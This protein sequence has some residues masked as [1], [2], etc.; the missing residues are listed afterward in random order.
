MIRALLALAL[1]FFA[2]VGGFF[3]RPSPYARV[4]G[5]ARARSRPLPE[6]LPA[7]VERFYR[8]RYGTEL[9][10][11]ETAVVS[12]HAWLRPAGPWYLP[13]R[14]RFVHAAGRDYLHDIAL[15]WYGLGVFR[16]D[17]RFVGGR[18]RMA[19]PF[20]VEEHS[21]QLA[22]AATL[23]LWAE[24]AW[25]PTLWVTHEEARW[26]PVD[27]TSATLVVPFESDELR[28]LIRFARG[29]GD[30]ESLEAERYRGAADEVPARWSNAAREWTTI[31]GRWRPRVGS[32]A[33]GDDPPWAVFTVTSV[34]EN[35]EVEALL[36]A[37]WRR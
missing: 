11:V 24:A 3:V 20:G 9:P 30:V 37:P 34:D 23:A 26:E 17:E 18:A 22:Q 4:G 12:G 1:L 27:E 21:P 5:A 15:T 19:L 29:S 7:P 16:V 31:D 36:N 6:G 32:V 10:V 14:F 35:V 13:A 8:A 28:A 2:V 33:W 25:F